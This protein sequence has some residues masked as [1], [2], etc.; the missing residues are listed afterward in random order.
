MNTGYDRV[1]GIVGGM[2]PEAG[3]A[4]FNYIISH[5]QG[6]TD[7][8]HLSVV[9]MSFPKHIV[10]R[11]LFLEGIVDINPAYGIV[12]VIKKLEQAGAGVIGIACN[13]SHA[14]AIFNVILEELQK[15]NSRVKLLNMPFETCR[16][17]GRH[18]PQIHR[19][20]VMATNGTYKSQV[21]EILLQEQ[22]YEVIVPDFGFQNEVIHKM[23]YDPGFGIKSNP[24]RITGEVSLLMKE[25]LCYFKKKGAEAII[26]GCTELSFTLKEKVVHD[27]IVIDATEILALS[28]ISE[29][30]S[31]KKSRVVL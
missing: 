26:L 24:G 28:L 9:L 6:R 16:F 14:P 15:T 7:Q 1:I 17:I 13:T 4:L 23:I 3:V 11:T 31:Y 12:Q 18:Y 5:T 22:G 30:V 19:I 2:G 10:D 20:G 21:Y 8:E 25:A 29:A 27:M